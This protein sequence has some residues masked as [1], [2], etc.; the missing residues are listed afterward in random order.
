MSRLS[1][2]LAVMVSCLFSNFVAA[3]DS[4]G[5]KPANPPTL[6]WVMA[7]NHG[8]TPPE[9]IGPTAEGLRFNLQVNEG[10]TLGPNL[11]GRILPGGAARVIV[12]TDGVCTFQAHATAKTEDGALYLIEAEGACDAGSEGYKQFIDGKAPPLIKLWV[13]SKMRSA[14][15]KYEWLNRRQFVQFGVAD[16]KN[17][18]V[19]YDV[20]SMK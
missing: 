12:R 7:Y 19:A 6:E 1:S 16:M 8:F 3:D 13:V 18:T 9:I 10:S 2:A 11:P 20:Y 14:H 15:P 4:A 17:G 5:S